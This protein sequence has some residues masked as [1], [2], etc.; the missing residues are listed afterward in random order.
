MWRGRAGGLSRSTV[1]VAYYEYARTVERAIVI[2]RSSE[3]RGSNSERKEEAFA[4][5]LLVGCADTVG[6]GVHC[7]A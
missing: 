7:T 4:K 5:I 1:L 3:Q 2:K 6:E